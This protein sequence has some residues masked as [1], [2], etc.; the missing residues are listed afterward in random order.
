MNHNDLADSETLAPEDRRP[1]FKAVLRLLVMPFAISVVSVLASRVNYLLFHTLAEL[2]SIVIAL[3]AW[4]VASTSRY[5]TRNHFT[6]YVAV[7]I[8]WCAALDLVHTLAYKGMHLLALEDANTPTQFWIAARFIQALALLASPLFLRRSVRIEYLHAGFGLSALAVTLWIFSGTFPAAFIEGQGLTAFKINA[9]YVIIGMLAASGVLLWRQRMQMSPRLSLNMQMALVAMILSEFA[10]TRYV[11]VYGEANLVGHIFKIFAY[12]FVY[13][14]LVQSTLREP[15]SMLARTA[16]TYDAVPDPAFVI[17]DDGRI[18]QAN[19]AAGRYAG[20][21]P[22][23]LIGRSLHFLFHAPDV[24]PEDCPVCTRI[25][26]GEASFASDIERG[27]GLGTVEC[28]VTPFVIEG[29]HR[30]YVQVVRD[31]TERKRAE[32]QIASY[33]KQLEASMRGTLQAV[34]NMIDLRDPYTA[35]HQRRVGEVARAI[36]REM[37]WSEERCQ[38]LEMVGLVHDIGKVAVPA[39]IL[40][41]PGRLTAM[42]MELVKGHAQAGY[43]VLKDVPFSFPV[44][45]VIRQHHERLDGSGYPRGLK[46]DEILPEARVLAVS[47]VLESMSA[48]RPYRPALEL[49]MALGELERGRGT[50]FDPEVLDAAFRL[51]RD[52]GYSLPK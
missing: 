44:A 6:V 30:S 23:A 29:S 41:K 32:E 14:A 10:F 20:M 2:F 7:A 21:P 34:S 4:V 22:E 15:F 49:D 40:S 46:G 42:E 26:R 35:G 45:E 52:K 13:L 1:S 28:S 50:L 43:E 12:W 38:A 33:V 8:G 39:E 16:S 25:A 48:H 3:T 9:E 17:R 31:I 18:Q 36:A 5:F 11:S 37:G 19:Q 24:R 27:K 51:L 47:D